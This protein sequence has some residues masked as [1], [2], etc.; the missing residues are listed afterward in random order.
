MPNYCSCRL[1]VTGPKAAIARFR[2]L[3]IRNDEF[4]F[5][6]VVPKPEALEGL[7]CGGAKLPD[8]T[9]VSTWR[10]VKDADGKHVGIEAVDTKRLI[11]L[12]G[13]ANWY[14]WCCAFWG[15]K[16]DVEARI[17]DEFDGFAANFETAWSPP[18]EWLASAS[19]KFPSL[20]FSLAYAEGGVGFWGTTEAERG[21]LN[22]CCTDDEFWL[23][24][25]ED[26]EDDD[27]YD[28]EDTERVVEPLREHLERY[29]L[30]TGG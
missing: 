7:C 10:E 1:E 24:Q 13:A 3:A 11:E 20:S 30:G 15:T 21:D 16:W 28:R 17:D 29:K 9:M 14:D 2:K 6:H 25:P 19:K 8:G 5:N 22:D 23:D 18:S 26:V 12:Y 4:K 27:W